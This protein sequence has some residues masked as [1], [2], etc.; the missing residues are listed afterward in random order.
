MAMA[1]AAALPSCEETKRGS[2]RAQALRNWTL[3]GRRCLLLHK[4]KGRGSRRKGRGWERDL[5]GTHEFEASGPCRG[6]VCPRRLR[7]LISAHLRSA[8]SS[9]ALC[10]R[11]GEGAH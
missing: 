2:G 5:G 9:M 1:A 6:C 11:V 8:A 7:P 4:K 10:R 3:V